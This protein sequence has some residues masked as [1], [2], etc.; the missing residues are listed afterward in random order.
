MPVAFHHH[1]REYRLGS[2]VEEAGTGEAATVASAD[3][4]VIFY[5]YVELQILRSPG[6]GLEATSRNL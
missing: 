1:R 5:F 4:R 2:W 3:V 6:G